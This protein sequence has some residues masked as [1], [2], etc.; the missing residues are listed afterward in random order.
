MRPWKPLPL[1]GTD[2]VDLLD[3]SEISDGD[4]LAEPC[5]SS[6]FSTRTSRRKR[7]GSHASL[8]EVTSH[9]LVHVLGLDVAETD[10]D[11]IIAVRLPEF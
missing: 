6:P 9:G 1:G 7:T 10:L 8:G 11:G 2:D 3:I 5:C 4:D